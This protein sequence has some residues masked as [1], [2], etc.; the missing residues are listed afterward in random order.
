M[1]E[2]LKKAGL[3]RVNI[4]LDSLKEDR[5]GVLQE[6]GILIKFL[7]VLKNLYPSV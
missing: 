6:V 1:V 4:S 2:D 7:K 5:L 3:K